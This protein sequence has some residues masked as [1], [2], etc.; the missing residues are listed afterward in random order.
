LIYFQKAK[1]SKIMHYF[2]LEI[3]EHVTKL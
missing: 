2:A 1:A 3:V